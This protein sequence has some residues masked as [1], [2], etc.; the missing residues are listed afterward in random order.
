M[1]Q[2]VAA[3][4]AM[5]AATEATRVVTSFALGLILMMMLGVFPRMKQ[6]ARP[7]LDRVPLTG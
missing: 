6:W 7:S 4:A 5:A 1:A 2:T 3:E